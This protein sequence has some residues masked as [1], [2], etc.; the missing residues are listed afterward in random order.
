MRRDAL[1]VFFRRA[2]I[3]ALP[4]AGACI[5]GGTC[6]VPGS[7]DVVV[8]GGFS[9]G[10]VTAVDTMGG[11]TFTQAGRCS[12]FCPPGHVSCEP[13]VQN[14]QSLVH[15]NGGRCLGRAPANLRAARAPSGGDAIGR[16]LAI[17]AHLEAASVSAFERLRD[18]LRAHGAPPS[19]IRAAERARKDEV[20]HARMT[21]ALAKRHGAAPPPVEL[22]GDLPQ[23]RELESIAVENAVEG[24]ARES[25]G[26]LI[27]TWQSR[28]AG[29]PRLRALAESIAP[30]ETR[31]A[32]L[33]WAVARWAEPRLS[34]AAR[35]RVRDA[36]RR[37]LAELAAAAAVE[38]APILVERLGLP[39]ARPALALA[40]ALADEAARRA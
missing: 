30:D 36:R 39:R 25:W 2:V 8:D 21:A 18:E 1:A 32:E 19:L 10:D 12:A 34:A 29:D 24:C 6:D 13:S 27:A 9:D 38:P 16:E 37:A 31:H 22:C 3:A 15:C 33:A 40:R 14:G 23:V 17:A 5:S 11:I 7:V 26:A 4:L 28:T 20:R 35:R